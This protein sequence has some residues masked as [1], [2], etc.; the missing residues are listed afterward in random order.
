MSE[1]VSEPISEEETTIISENLELTKDSVI[2]DRKVVL[3][4]VAI[5][6]FEHDLSIIA[7]VFVSNHSVIQN[8]PEGHKSK[9][10]KQMEEAEEIS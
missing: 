1:S 3:N 5:K 10:K 7:E 9:E 4:M 2:Q 6:T 8:F